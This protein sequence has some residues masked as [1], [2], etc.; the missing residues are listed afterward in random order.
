MVRDDP[1]GSA[2]FVGSSALFGLPERIE[3][4]AEQVARVT[5][6]DVQRA[7]QSYFDPED[8]HVTCVGVLDEALRSDVR[9]LAGA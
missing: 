6:D 7:V 1:E 8:A 3:V 9:G 2:G 4:I 5:A